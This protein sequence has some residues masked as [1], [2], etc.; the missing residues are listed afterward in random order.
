MRIAKER[1]DDSA[2]QSW[3][4]QFYDRYVMLGSPNFYPFSTLLH[5]VE[6]L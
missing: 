4:T 3:Q 6:Q 5:S 1:G 2:L